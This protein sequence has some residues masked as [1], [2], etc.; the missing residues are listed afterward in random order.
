MPCEASLTPR[1]APGHHPLT[2]QSPCWGCCPPERHT[3]SPSLLLQKV[4]PQP[5]P[6]CPPHV[7]RPPTCPSPHRSGVPPRHRSRTYRKCPLFLWLSFVLIRAFSCRCLPNKGPREP[8]TLFVAD[9]CLGSHCR[10]LLRPNPAWASPAGPQPRP[11]LWLPPHT[12]PRTRM[13]A[14]PRP[15]DD[16]FRPTQPGPRSVWPSS[17]DGSFLLCLCLPSSREKMCVAL[18]GP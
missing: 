1:S 14:R 13:R 16:S 15:Q 6:P 4:P 2:C 11:L 18:R 8:G 3:L 5:S 12:P 17:L 9:S 7:R 10:G